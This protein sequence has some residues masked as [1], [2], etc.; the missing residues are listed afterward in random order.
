MR[1]YLPS[2]RTRTNSADTNALRDQ[3]V[4][5]LT[6]EAEKIAKQFSDQFSQSL[7]SQ[8]E[9]AFS[10]GGFDIG[11]LSK[12]VSSGVRYFVNRPKTTSTTRESVRSIDSNAQFRVSN[13]QAAAE[14]QLALNKGDKNL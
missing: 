10:G 7:Q 14:A 3:F 9:Q 5:Q 12:L 6:S 2:S 11:N 8:A 13:A 1:R 4:R